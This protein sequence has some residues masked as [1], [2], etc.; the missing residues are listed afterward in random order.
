MNKLIILNKVTIVSCMSTI[1]TL[2]ML[3]NDYLNFKTLF[4]QSISDNHY[5]LSGIIGG[6]FVMMCQE[7]LK[8]SN[9]LS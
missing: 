3:N 8:L 9:E 2:T 7:Y 6:S 1:L 5:L 4:K